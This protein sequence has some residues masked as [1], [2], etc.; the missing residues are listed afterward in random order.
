M[1]LNKPKFLKLINANLMCSFMS[2]EV[3]ETIFLFL[4]FFFVVLF[5]CLV[6]F[7]IVDSLFKDQVS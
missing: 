5:W 1:E 4:S 3:F 2:K 6:W 7:S